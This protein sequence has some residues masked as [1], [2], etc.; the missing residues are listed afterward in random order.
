MRNPFKKQKG[1][2]F[3]FKKACKALED[4]ATGL[5]SIVHTREFDSL[6]EMYDGKAMIFEIMRLVRSESKHALLQGIESAGFLPHWSGFYEKTLKEQD[7]LL[8]YC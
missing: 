2:S 6:F 7:S 1:F 5:P 8:S 4:Y 3:R